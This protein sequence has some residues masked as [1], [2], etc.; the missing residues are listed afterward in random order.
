MPETPETT[1]IPPAPVPRSRPLVV[2]LVGL[3][4]AVVVV[5]AL[6]A[7]WR[8]VRPGLTEEEVDVAVL[9]TLVSES[10]ASF[11]ITGTLEF[12]TT[13]ERENRQRLTVPFTPFDMQVGATRVTVRLPGRVGYGFDVRDIGADDVRLAEDGTVEVDLPELSAFSVEPILERA[14]VRTDAS[15]W[16]MIDPERGSGVTTRALGVARQ[17]MRQQA[18]RHLAE[19]QAPRMNAARAV[20]RMLTPALQAAGATTLRYRVRIGAGAVLELEGEGVEVGGR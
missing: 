3:F 17:R 19:S 18:D 4:V 10:E 5:V 1:P 16:A 14:Q 13:V 15:G 11:L 6:Y 7:V 2:A 9:T 12:G 8:T 20:V